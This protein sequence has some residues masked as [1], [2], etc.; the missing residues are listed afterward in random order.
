MSLR[1]DKVF[2]QTMERLENLF[3]FAIFIFSAVLQIKIKFTVKKKEKKRDVN[4]QIM[5]TMLINQITKILF[6][7]II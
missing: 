6:A 7:F 4:N 2:V 1:Q 3:I 5:Q